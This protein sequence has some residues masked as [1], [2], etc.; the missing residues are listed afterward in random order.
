MR[1]RG[2]NRSSETRKRH[3]RPGA[4]RA[5]SPAPPRRSSA[6]TRG[7]RGGKRR[8][9][10]TRGRPPPGRPPKVPLKPG[11]VEADP[12]QGTDQADL[13]PDPPVR[14]KER[15][16]DQQGNAPRKA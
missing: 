6:G 12:L 7:R 13:S 2:W 14:K 9:G 15:E 5:R 8:R 11:G 10:P 3:G 4:K 1:A 16:D